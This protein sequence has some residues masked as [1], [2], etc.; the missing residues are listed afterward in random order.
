MKKGCPTDSGGGMLSQ[1]RTPTGVFTRSG[2]TRRTP[3]KGVGG[4]E[5]QKRPAASPIMKGATEG[6][7]IKRGRSTEAPRTSEVEEEQVLPGTPL[8]TEGSTSS[9]VTGPATDGL[10]E[11]RTPLI[12]GELVALFDII[13]MAKK[14]V[15]SAEIL[16]SRV[17]GK[18]KLSQDIRTVANAVG[19]WATKL[20]AAVD[21]FDPTKLAADLAKPGSSKSIR[22]ATECARAEAIRTRLTEDPS[23]QE[24][25]NLLAEKWPA[26]AFTRTLL[27]RRSIATSECPTR[28]LVTDHDGNLDTIEKMLAGQ[29]P[30]VKEAA[31]K[32]GVRQLRAQ[33]T[34]IGPEGE[35]LCQAKT[36]VVCGAHDT[37]NHPEGARA[38]ICLQYATELMEAFGNEPEVDVV[39]PEEGL[40]MWRK[41]LEIASRGHESRITIC[42]RRTGSST[43]AAPRNPNPT[44]TITVSGEGMSYAELVKSIGNELKDVTVNVTRV[45]K[46][47]NGAARLRI[48]GAPGSASRIGA[49]L[50]SKIAGAEVDTSGRRKLLRSSH[51]APCTTALEVVDAVDKALGRKTKSTVVSMRPAYG[52]SIRANILVPAEDAEAIT[53]ARDLRIGL[54]TGRFT[55]APKRCRRCWATGHLAAQCKGQDRSRL[56]MRC[57]REGHM[58]RDCKED[59]T[60]TPRNSDKAPPTKL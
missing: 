52:G 51:L 32:Q 40:Y 21:A 20:G 57:S 45:T 22:E 2:M 13:K 47:E 38:P 3:P 15:A 19:A 5:A 24:L 39:V 54:V 4:E 27:K 35:T 58:A 56:C 6:T 25:E 9:P 7:P 28:A 53:A 29:F 42:T 41:A 17:D 10:I 12:E 31:K 60:T 44:E 50:S 18:A 37:L 8:A 43:K 23:S 1:A 16:T 26:A 48:A 49:I 11:E 36:L 55:E 33:Y 59:R 46:M 34:E 14:V 30:G